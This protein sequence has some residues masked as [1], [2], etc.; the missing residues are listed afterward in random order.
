MEEWKTIPDHPDYEV[1]NLGNF[2]RRTEGQGTKAGKPRATY[3]NPVTGYRNVTF[4]TG[5]KGNRGTRTYSAHRIVAEVWIPNPDNLK[6][7]DHINM[8]RADNRVENLRWL[9]YKQNTPKKPL[10]LIAEGSLEGIVFPRTQDAQDFLK[11]SSVTLKKYKDSGIPYK[12]YYI[13]SFDK[14]Q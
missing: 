11:M 7:V 2:R 6:C 3:I 9:T 13:E 14:K 8:D 10:K 1:S 5:K 12:G 4:G